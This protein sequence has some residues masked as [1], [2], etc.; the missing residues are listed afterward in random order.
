MIEERWLKTL[1]FKTHND[2]RVVGLAGLGSQN[3][4]LKMERSDGE[5][6][7]GVT[8]NTLG[9]HIKEIPP[10]LTPTPV[11]EC[12]A[13]NDKLLKL[14]G[15]DRFD[16]MTT[17]YADLYSMIIKVLS[18]SGVPAMMLWHGTPESV[19]AIPFILHSPPIRRRLKEFVEW[20]LDP[21][22]PLGRMPK[23]QV[24]FR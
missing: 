3:V 13:V 2:G 19:E 23:L 1:S 8:R 18:Q 22:N 10:I 15:N 21:K 4:A 5:Y 14:V 6:V 12:D 11:Y 16:L 7:I 17:W 9:F 20:P 24:A